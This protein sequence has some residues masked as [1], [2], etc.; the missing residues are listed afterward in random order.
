MKKQFC[1]A[2]ISLKTLRL[3]TCIS[4]LVFVLFFS[5]AVSANAAG[6]TGWIEVHV[7]VPDGFDEHIIICFENSD[8]GEEYAFRILEA[9]DYES[10]FQLPPGNYSFRRA[11]LENNDFRYNT[12]LTSGDAEFTVSDDSELALP[13]T[14]ETTYNASFANGAKPTEPPTEPTTEVTEPIDE[15]EAS[16]SGQKGSVSGSGSKDPIHNSNNTDP[17]AT[18]V[19]QSTVGAEETTEPSV[20]ETVVLQTE[21]SSFASGTESNGNNVITQ[22]TQ[23]PE[24]DNG[25]MAES[26]GNTADDAEQSEDGNFTFVQKL[27]FSLIGAAVFALCVFLFAYLYR[28]HLEDE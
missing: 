7:S 16:D 1:F 14:F 8:T 13:F 19:T 12:R 21:G 27:L 23:L 15:T 4:M 10:F 25:E 22:V 5:F 9:N 2:G 11:F 3:F 18:I 24:S 20:E 28:R 26:E 6:K 17:E